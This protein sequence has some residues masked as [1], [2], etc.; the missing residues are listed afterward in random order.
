MRPESRGPECRIVDGDILVI[1]AS[2]SEIV[3]GGYEISV[4]PADL[5]RAKHVVFDLRTVRT[6]DACG[7]G[8]VARFYNHAKSHDGQVVFIVLEGSGTLR[9]LERAGYLQTEGIGRRAQSID[10]ALVAIRTIS[11]SEA[12]KQLM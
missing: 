12:I 2:V 5:S 7:C 4:T 1:E 10:H 6:I 8:Q 3:R 9:V 11:S